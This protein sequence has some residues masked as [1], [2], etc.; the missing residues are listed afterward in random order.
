MGVIIYIMNKKLVNM[1]V[2]V[3]KGVESGFKR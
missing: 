1:F 3:K 2:I